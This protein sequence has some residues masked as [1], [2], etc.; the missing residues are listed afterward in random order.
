[1]FERL[2]LLIL[3]LLPWQTRLIFADGLTSVYAVEL[4]ILG[5]FFFGQRLRILHQHRTPVRWLGIVLVASLASVALA[6]NR[7]LAFFLWLHIVFAALLFLLLLDQRLNPLPAAV[8]FVAG[9]LIPVG[10]GVYQ[11]FTG[12]AFASSWLGLAAHDAGVL[13][14]SV[15]EG[16]ASRWLRAYGTFDHPN[17]F[18]GYVATALLC[19]LGLLSRQAKGA[20][21]H[22]LF[23]LS[24]LC[25]FSFALVISFSRSAWLAFLL[26]LFVSGSLLLWKHRVR[27]VAAL[28]FLSLTLLL[29]AVS[30]AIFADP[31]FSRFS[32][33]LRLEARSLTERS[34]EYQQ[35]PEVFFERPLTGVGVGGYL[36][37]LEALDP[38]QPAWS[39]QPIHNSLLLILA[40]VGIMGAVAMLLWAVSIDKINYAAI[41]HGSVRAIT[42]IGLGT[43]LL[44]VALLDHYLWSS[45]SGL[46]LL[47]FSM[48]MTLR[49]SED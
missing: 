25:L 38:G 27:A 2:V 47:A 16:V 6:I 34:S 9:L 46:V 36:L 39:Y 33:D 8:A 30:V 42:A 13:G 4:L 40:E 29:L 12:D 7:E 5:T 3:F 23:L 1:M 32:P 43:I 14:P 10:L 31:V 35:F 37:A 26:A 49:L 24:L 17:I 19:I 15:I 28:P 18:G 21:L 41:R 20:R 11:V 22:K 45:W 44:V 48:A